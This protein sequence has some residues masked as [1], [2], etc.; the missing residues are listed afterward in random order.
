MPIDTPRVWL[1]EQTYDLARIELA[2]CTWSA[3]RGLAGIH[4]QEHASAGTTA[5]TCSGAPSGTTAD[6]ARRPAWC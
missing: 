6:D 1:T 4:D 5:S 2:D 3:P